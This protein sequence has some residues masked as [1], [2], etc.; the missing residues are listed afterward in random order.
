MRHSSK[1][2]RPASRHGLQGRR[3][4][5]CDLVLDGIEGPRAPASAVL[6]L[7]ESLRAEKQHADALSQARSD[8]LACVQQA[9]S[10]GASFTSIAAAIIPATGRIRDT[11]AARRR[12]ANALV[13]RVHAA[14][15]RQR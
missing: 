14:R 3:R 15:Q 11:I 9:R 12:A 5:G 8:I 2:R 13:C 7:K 4:R 10:A 1:K 6:C